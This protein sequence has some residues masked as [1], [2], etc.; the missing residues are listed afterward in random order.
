VKPVVIINNRTYER[1]PVKTHLISFGEDL[2]QIMQR[3]AGPLFLQGDWIAVSE[4]VVSVCQNN[5]RHISTVKAGR[6]AKLIVRGVKKYPNDIGFSRPEKMQLVVEI[7]GLLRVL[8]AMA[9]GAL[10]KLVGIHGIFWCVAGKR[11][12]E[13]DGFNPAAMYPYTEYA[14]LPPQEPA[15]VC[16]EIEDKLGMPAVMIDGNNINVKIIAQSRQVP[17]DRKEARL[18]LLDNPMGQDRELTPF[19]IVRKVR[20]QG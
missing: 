6:L 12:A 1:I 2:V 16:Q 8:P 14:A 9:L 18:I 4:K 10:G 5:V 15:R 13:I 3:Y 17:V 11:V 19:I 20:E 7:S